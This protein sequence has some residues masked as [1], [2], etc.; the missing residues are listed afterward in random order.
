MPT[1]MNYASMKTTANV[2]REYVFIS[3]AYILMNEISG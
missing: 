3:L 2:L 1:D